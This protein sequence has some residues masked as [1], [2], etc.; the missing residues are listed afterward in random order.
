MHTPHSTARSFTK[1]E[2]KLLKSLDT[3]RKVQDF[4]DGLPP[5]FEPDGDECRSPLLVLRTL[6]AHCIEAAMFA[7]M[8]LRMHGRRALL[9][10]LAANTKDDDHVLAVFQDSKTRCWGA[11]AKSNHYCNGYRDPVYRSVRELMMSYFHEYL[12]YAGEKTLRSYAGPLDLARFDRL[13]WTTRD[14]DVW[15]IPSALVGLRHTRILTRA[16][17]RGLR[18]ADEFVRRVNNIERYRRGSR[19]RFLPPYGAK[20]SK[21]KA[22]M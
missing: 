8:A 16:Q 3:P 9:V 5:N 22:N 21:G 17:E 6:T 13:G 1:T 14:G 12:N 4:L 2:L 10:D 19:K 11:V 7:A 15:E 18:P 20:R